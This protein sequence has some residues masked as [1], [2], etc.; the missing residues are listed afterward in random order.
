MELLQPGRE[1]EKEN[2][3]GELVCHWLNVVLR[4]VEHKCK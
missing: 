1:R 4:R 3:M 2:E